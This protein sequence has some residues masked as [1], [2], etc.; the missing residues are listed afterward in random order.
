MYKEKIKF[1]SINKD[2]LK[3]I[4]IIFL[5]KLKVDVN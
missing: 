1:V 4:T 2:K 5:K 3:A